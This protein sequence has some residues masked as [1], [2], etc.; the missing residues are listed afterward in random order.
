MTFSAV[1][2]AAF[3]TSWDGVGQPSLA[4]VCM[5]RSARP[6]GAMGVHP[7]P[8]GLTI[9]LSDIPYCITTKDGGACGGRLDA[10][11]RALSSARA[12]AT[13][14]S[15]PEKRD[16]HQAG[17]GSPSHHQRA[18]GPAHQPPRWRPEATRPPTRRPGGD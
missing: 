1:L 15:T 13:G 8:G 18:D 17:A 9:D 6:Q 14:T 12:V 5:W 7:T 10:G 2:P 3:S 16:R 11:L 4:V